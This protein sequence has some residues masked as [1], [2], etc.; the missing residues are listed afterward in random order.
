MASDAFEALRTARE[1]GKSPAGNELSFN[2]I[3]DT[4]N[5]L[6][7][8]PVVAEAYRALTGDTI[9]PQAK[10]AGGALYGGPIGLVLSAADAAIEAVS[11]KDVGQHVMASLFGG[12]EPGVS[13]G[14][15]P[16]ASVL[17]EAA[18]PAADAP[19]TT[20]SVVPASTR[21]ARIVPAQPQTPAQTQTQTQ[22]QIQGSA[23]APVKLAS[24]TPPRPMPQLSP[25]AFNALIGSFD[26]PKAA[27]AANPEMAKKVAEAQTAAQGARATV[28]QPP[29][30]GS[31][32]D[33]FGAMQTNL[34]RLDA[35][36]AANPN[37][38]AAAFAGGDTGGF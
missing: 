20:A 27:K 25:D 24:S 5:P 35:L 38:P 8:I 28:S 34:D 6:Q 23:S 10:V 9:S 31:T 37:L 36:K 13:P 2:D 4:L 21:A 7:H 30:M 26:D 19:E 12:G 11:G 17:A 33:L 18:K 29:A 1:Q 3:L 32:P 22:A 15:S 14:T 16:G